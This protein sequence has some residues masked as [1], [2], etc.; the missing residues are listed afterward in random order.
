MDAT[1]ANYRD[2]IVHYGAQLLNDRVIRPWDERTA[3]ASFERY[4]T[5]ATE[6]D[7]DPEVWERLFWL[8]FREEL[9][10]VL[11]SKCSDRTGHGESEEPKE[12]S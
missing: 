8:R 5:T 4:R 11:R 12:T 7:R 10:V 6:Y 2:E 9:A 1:L 3:S